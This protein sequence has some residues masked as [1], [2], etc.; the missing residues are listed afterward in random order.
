MVVLHHILEARFPVN[1]ASDRTNGFRRQ[2]IVAT[3]VE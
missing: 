1:A 2:R 3:L